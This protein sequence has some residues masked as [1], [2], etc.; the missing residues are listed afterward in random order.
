M[1]ER[2]RNIFQKIPQL[3]QTNGKHVE[4]KVLP[5]KAVDTGT[6]IFQNNLRVCIIIL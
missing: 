6:E 4:E 1:K 2:K 5:Y 3:I